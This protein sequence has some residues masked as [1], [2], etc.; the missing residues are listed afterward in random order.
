MRSVTVDIRPTVRKEMMMTAAAAVMERAE[1]DL[2]TRW[3]AQRKLLK[4]RKFPC[5]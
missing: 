4:V 5:A 3:P 2:M 1:L